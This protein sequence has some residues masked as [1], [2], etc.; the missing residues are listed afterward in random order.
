MPQGLGAQTQKGSAGGSWG[1]GASLRR[2]MLIMAESPGS[3]GHSYVGSG[4]RI[5]TSSPGMFPFA[6]LL[7]LHSQQV[8]SGSVFLFPYSAWLPSNYTK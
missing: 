5:L 6:F 3:D 7:F 8:Y 1:E 2:C 4:P